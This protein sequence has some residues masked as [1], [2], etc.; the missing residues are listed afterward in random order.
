MPA[1][2][3]TEVF[4]FDELSDDARDRARAW[5]SEGALDYDWW[6]FVYD[7]FSSIC[8][9]LGID[10]KTRPVRLMGGDTRR[11]PCIQFSG[12]CS[13]GDGASFEVDLYAY[14]RNSLT[15]IKAHAPND[16]ELHDIAARL[17][18]IQRRNFY[19]LYARVDQRGRYVH[20]NTMQVDVRRDDAEMTADAGDTITEAMRD[21]ARWL[22]RQLQSEYDHLTSD[23]SVEDGI[24]ANEYTF[25]EAGRR[26]G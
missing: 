5:C 2:I 19:Q 15:Q 12:F 1:I 9:I 22:Y 21:L 25:T 4:T 24:I 13:Q 17:N 3:K 14:A 6:S 18:A 10:L 8:K 23:E 20:E 7:D 16:R 11:K 26:F